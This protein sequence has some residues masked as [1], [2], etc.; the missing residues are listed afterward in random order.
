MLAIVCLTKICLDKLICYA[1][2]Y[3]KHYF[4]TYLMKEFYFEQ[5]IE[6]TIMQ[7]DKSVQ[8]LK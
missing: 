8:Y 1:V 3:Q 4:P 5:H 2:R 7:I 6:C